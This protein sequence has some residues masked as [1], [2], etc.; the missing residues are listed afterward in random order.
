VRERLITLAA[1]LGA[2]AL[3]AAVCVQPGAIT[4][5]S[6]D[7]PRPATDEQRT[8]GYHAVFVWLEMEGVKVVSLRERLTTLEGR[9]DLRSRGNL[10]VVTLPGVT[11]FASG[12][13][14]ALDRW[15]RA[16]NTLLVLAALDDAPEWAADRAALAPADV[17]LLTGLALEPLRRSV[18][19]PGVIAQATRSSSATGDVSLLIP[20]GGHIYFQNVR[21]AAALSDEMRSG[22]ARQAWALRIPYGGFALELAHA[23]S[24]GAGVLWTRPLG[25]GRIIV[26]AFGSL[27]TNRAVA[28]PDNAQLLANLVAANVM[29][30]GTV[31]FDDLRQG[32]G[33]VYDPER[34]FRDPRLYGTVS[35]LLALWLTWVLG[36]TRLRAR[37]AHSSAPREADLLRAT[38]GLLAR[39]VANAE[40]ARSLFAHFFASIAPARAGTSRDPQGAEP[41]EYLER[42]PRV[43]AADLERLK[44][45]YAHAHAGRRIPLHRLQ[46]LI[47]R[48]ERRLRS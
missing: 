29:R 27:F 16:G 18:R 8:N 14:Q 40:A 34:F 7:V 22:R 10:L 43:S 1:A 21:E 11:G 20:N 36:S 42:H 47:A 45:W 26:S 17:N 24:S 33:A 46:D 15:I 31:I 2:L 12:E 25:A 5:R 30:H 9:R 35:I 6:R 41:W 19:L 38:G 3:F 39:V 32:R 28:L 37:E 13:L 44:R 48:I 4:Q 23:R